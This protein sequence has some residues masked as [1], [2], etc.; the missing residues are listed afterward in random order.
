[1]QTIFCHS[2]GI[3]I[4]KSSTFCPNCGAK[5]Q[6][7]V[8]NSVSL[9]Q[10]NENFEASIKKPFFL[11]KWF[12]IITI[13]VLMVVFGIL[14]KEKEVWNGRQFVPQSEFDKEFGK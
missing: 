10:S 7:K 12:I 9:T 13:V 8:T 1:M 2:C 14:T 5:K 11:N 3:K 6:S 4:L